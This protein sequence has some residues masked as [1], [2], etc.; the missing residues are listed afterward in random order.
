MEF[1]G[2]GTSGSHP[3]SCSGT[4]TK[5]ICLLTEH[6]WFKKT[7]CEAVQTNGTESALIPKETLEDKRA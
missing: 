3:N 2:G 1:S 5:R 7:G 6:T 4:I